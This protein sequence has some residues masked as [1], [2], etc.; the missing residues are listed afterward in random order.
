MPFAIQYDRL[1]GP[2]VLELREIAYA[3]PG[4]GQAVVEVR[5]IGV[6]PIDWKIRSGL[7]RSA[8]LEGWR[9]VG[10]DAAGVVTAVA[11]DVEGFSVGDEVIVAEA[12]GSYAT[13]IAVDVAKLSAKP[14]ALP[15]EQAAAIPVP[16]G[17]AHQVLVSL[18]VGEGDTLLWH[19]GSGAVG[20]IGIQLARRA[21][22]TVVA[23]AS[24]R[25]QAHLRELGAIP[26]VYGDGILERVHEV[27]PDGVTVAVDAAGTREAIEVS[28][29]LVAD[30]GRIGTIVLGAEA[31]DLGIRAWRGGSPAPLTAEEEAARAEAVPLIAGLAAEGALQI[32]IAHR[33]PLADA[34]EAHRQSETGHVRGKIVLLP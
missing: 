15:W 26:V 30:P 8:P 33:Y 11:S 5:A 18:G 23:T 28:K 16:G 3:T 1:G 6:N 21:G 32:E 20:Q 2:E 12:D 29:A 31:A 4:P 25:N 14:A 7:R 13:E 22:A 9:T 34:A 10:G 19:G 27:A 24:E 17:T